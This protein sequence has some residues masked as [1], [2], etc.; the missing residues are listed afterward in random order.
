MQRMP[1]C[2]AC[3]TALPG[4]RSVSRGDAAGRVEAPHP[5]G[6]AGAAVLRSQAFQRA[7]ALPL[8]PQMQKTSLCAV[9]KGVHPTF[10][11]VRGGTNDRNIY[12]HRSSPGLLTRHVPPCHRATRHRVARSTRIR[13]AIALSGRSVSHHPSALLARSQTR[14]FTK[15]RRVRLNMHGCAVASTL[16][17]SC[18]WFHCARSIG[19]SQ[20]NLERAYYLVVIQ[21]KRSRLRWLNKESPALKSKIIP[22]FP[23][24]GA[25]GHARLR[26]TRI[27]PCCAL[28]GHY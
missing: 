24:R 14:I 27:S 4:A 23:L 18:H 21:R 10:T 28:R 2:C 20:R 1:E 16:A 22:S 7:R 3:L 25:Y 17:D 9:M 19:P 12:M 26:T 11:F 5:C 15:T 13:S 8:S 6:C